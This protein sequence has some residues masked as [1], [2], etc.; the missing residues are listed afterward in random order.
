MLANI[1]AHQAKLFAPR[2]TRVALVR[3]QL[4]VHHQLLVD[5]RIVKLVHIRTRHLTPRA[6]VLLAVWVLTLPLDYLYALI[7]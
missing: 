3:K 4:R 7:A 1:K 6:R 5:V 2:L